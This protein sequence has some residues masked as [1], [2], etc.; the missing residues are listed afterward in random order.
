MQ[1]TEQILYDNQI[2]QT[3]PEDAE[4]VRR[5][6][7]ADETALEI[8][9]KKHSSRIMS[10]A[11]R[12]LGTRCEAEEVTQDVFL[13]LWQYPARFDATKGTLITWL[14]I[15]ARSRALDLLRRIKAKNRRE[16]QL[17][18]KALKVSGNAIQSFTPDRDLTVQEVL[19]RLPP[20][21]ERVIRS[22]YFHGYALC[23]I[24][25]LQRLPLGT[26]K[27][28]ARFAMKRLR[29]ELTPL[30]LNSQSS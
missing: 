30:R 15:V 17:E 10:A 7:A 14:V 28:R 3:W 29:A 1:P 2:R 26:V 27:G 19:C 16:S 9:M 20:Q 13:A 6:C 25:A 22:A 23:E 18:F 11:F 5:V 21:Q 8:L 24:A 12:V 4:L